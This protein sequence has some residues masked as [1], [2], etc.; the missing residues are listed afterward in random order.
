[1]SVHEKLI[2]T[3]NLLFDK[4]LL[5]IQHNTNRAGCC[6]P[7]VDRSKQVATHGWRCRYVY[8]TRDRKH[9]AYLDDSD[10]D[11]DEIC[12]ISNKYLYRLYPSVIDGIIFNTMSCSGHHLKLNTLEFLYRHFT[13]VILYP[14]SQQFVL[15]KASHYPVLIIASKCQLFLRHNKTQLNSLSWLAW[16]IRWILLLRT[17]NLLWLP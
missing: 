16:E 15:R 3:E 5:S 6:A 8:P 2:Q 7:E 9:P 14:H 17:T 1:M 4:D 12:V 13:S 11:Q 10:T